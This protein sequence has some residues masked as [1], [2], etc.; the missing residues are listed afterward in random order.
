MNGDWNRAPY[1]I[2]LVDGVPAGICSVAEHSD[3]VFFSELQIL[4]EY[5]VEGLGTK[6]MKERMQYAKSLDLDSRCFVKITRRNCI[7]ALVS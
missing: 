4:P 3:H 6:I 5:Q 2:I 7:F 1:K